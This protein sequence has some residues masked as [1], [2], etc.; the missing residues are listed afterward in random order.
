[1]RRLMNF[2]GRKVIS[3]NRGS[4]TPN[5]KHISAPTR[6]DGIH[7]NTNASNRMNGGQ[8]YEGM[9]LFSGKVKAMTPGKTAPTNAPAPVPEKQTSP[10]KQ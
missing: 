10:E 9:D 5:N 4:A 2:S 3:L 6:R 1:M 7:R 8:R